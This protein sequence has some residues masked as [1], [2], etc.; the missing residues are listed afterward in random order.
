MNKKAAKS[1]LS[2]IEAQLED[3][4]L[5]MNERTE[6]KTAKAHRTKEKA[7]K[8]GVLLRLPDDIVDYLDQMAEA[9]RIPRTQ[10]ILRLILKD[11]KE[12]K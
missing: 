7:D 6:I 3:N 11:M 2:G 10:Y 9:D 4:Q 5:E 1:F 12:R 8:K